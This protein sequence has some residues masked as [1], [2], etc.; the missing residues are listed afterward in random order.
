MLQIEHE[1]HIQTFVPR[2]GLPKLLGEVEI[3]EENLQ[4][5]VYIYR[6]GW[7][8]L[9]AI[10]GGVNLFWITIFKIVLTYYKKNQ[11]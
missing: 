11:F 7:V 10:V 8:E 5:N 6:Q 3:Y 1:P 9:L 2:S 4:L